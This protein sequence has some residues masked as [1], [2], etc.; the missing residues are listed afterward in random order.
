MSYHLR[1]RGREHIVLERKRI[2]ERWHSE[3]WNSLFFQFPNWALK[4]PGFVYEGDRPDAFA[5]YREIAE[6]VEDYARFLGAPVRCGTE[7]ISLR[8]GFRRVRH[9]HQ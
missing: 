5:H 3:R 4:P 2:A 9:R 1:E 8:N 7:V 6:F